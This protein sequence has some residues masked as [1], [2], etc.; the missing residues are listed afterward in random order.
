MTGTLF[1]H[2]CPSFA[3]I[4]ARNQYAPNDIVSCTFE[5]L[6][7]NV[8]IECDGIETVN[9]MHQYMEVI[10]DKG[11]GNVLPLVTSQLPHE[12]TQPVC[13]VDHIQMADILERALVGSPLGTLHTNQSVVFTLQF[14]NDPMTLTEHA[15]E[16][17]VYCR[18]V[19]VIRNTFT[20]RCLLVKVLLHVLLGQLAEGASL[21]AEEFERFVELG[22]VSCC[23]RKGRV[24]NWRIVREEREGDER[25]IQE[26]MTSANEE[27]SGRNVSNIHRFE[28][29][30]I[31][32]TSVGRR[33]CCQREH[34]DI[35]W[36]QL[37]DHVSR[38]QAA[39]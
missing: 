26:N 15:P 32:Y 5:R 7:G 21:E 19:R 34:F 23:V 6:T 3:S 13:P 28:D 37:T 33:D 10:E 16:S 36:F 14:L 22:Y 12:P 30:T 39:E 24:S 35:C 4:S 27:P 1:D 25:P 31:K 11:L 29:G 38:V 17:G 9:H 2:Q 18:T 8:Q 20:I